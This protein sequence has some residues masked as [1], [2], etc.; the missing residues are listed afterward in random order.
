MIP[1]VRHGLVAPALVAALTL[2]VLAFAGSAAALAVLA[3]V[4]AAIVGWNLWHL[5]QLAT[6]AEA[7]ARR[8]GSPWP[9]H[10]GRDL[11]RHPSPGAHAR[12]A[13]ARTAPRDRTFP[14][15]SRST[16][17]RGRR[18]RRELPDRLGQSARPAPTRSRCGP[19][20]RTA[21]G[22]PRAAAR[23]PALSRGRRL[24][25]FSGRRVEPEP[26]PQARVAARPFRRRP[27]APDVARRDRARGCRADAARFHRQRVA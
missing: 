21:G 14:A 16:A 9:R 17:R 26:G 27:E 5:D 3:G 13:R 15:S 6:W 18:A 2:A 23:V 20:S 1:V 24:P 7:P 4:T 10:L 25:R 12:C 11:C 8:G 22:E 19:G